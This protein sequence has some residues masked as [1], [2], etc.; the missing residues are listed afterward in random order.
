MESW[1]DPLTAPWTRSHRLP[2]R[3]GGT[4]RTPIPHCSTPSA[5]PR[6]RDGPYIHKNRKTRPSRTAVPKSHFRQRHLPSPTAVEALPRSSNSIRS[7]AAN[8]RR[9]IRRRRQLRRTRRR[10]PAA[11]WCSQGKKRVRRAKTRLNATPRHIGI[12]SP[13]RRAGYGEKVSPASFPQAVLVYEV[14]DS[15]L[16]RPVFN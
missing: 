4:G 10:T 12:K 6:S 9:S 5:R 2:T 3:A 13:H 14:P 11:D 15:P 7:P 1:H 8:A 16:P